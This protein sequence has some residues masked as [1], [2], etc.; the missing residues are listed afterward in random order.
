[1]R[2]QSV[3]VLQIARELGI[4]NGSVLNILHDHLS[5]SKVCKYGVLIYWRGFRSRLGRTRVLNCW[6]S[7]V[8]TQTTFVLYCNWR[9]NVNPSLGS[10]HQTGVN[11]VETR[12][13][14]ATQEI[15]LSALGWKSHGHNFL[16]LQRCAAGGL[17]SRSDNHDWTILQWT[18]EKLLQAVKEKRRGMLTRCPLLLHDTA[19]AHACLELHKP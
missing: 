18:A 4:T 11:A 7:A 19:S 15:S 3:E 13:L 16:G 17:T 2:D 14:S 10:W 8:P 6:L 9:W 12:Q 5:L 1:M